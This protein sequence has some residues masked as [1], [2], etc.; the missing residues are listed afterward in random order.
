MLAKSKSWLS[1]LRRRDEEDAGDDGRQFGMFAGVFTPTVLTILGAIMYLRT[2]WVVGNAGL[3]GAIAI[4]LL[5][6]VITFTTGLAVSSVATNTRVGA[7]GAFAIISQSLGLEVGGSIGIPLVLAQSISIALYVLAFS[8]AW[9]R[10]FPAH[11]EPLVAVLSF[12]AVFIIAYISAKFASRTQFLILIIVGFSLVSIFLASFPILGQP[13]FTQDPVLVGDFQDAN[14]WETFAVFFPAVTGIMVG[15]SMSGTLRKPRRDIPIGTMSA[16]FL[17]LIIYLLLAFWLARIA[18]PQELLNNSTIMVDK[19]VWGWAVLAGILGATFSSALGSLV[20]APRVMQALALYE[21]F[22]FSDYFAQEAKNGEP[23]HAMYIAGGVGFVALLAALAGGGLDAIAGIITMFFLITYGMLNVVVLIEQTL[24]TV[25]FRPMLRVSRLVPFIGM[26]G[27]TFVMFLIQPIFSLIAAVLVVILYFYLSRRKLAILDTDVRSGLSATVAEWGVRRTRDMQAAPERTWK[28]VV[29][30]PVK[31]SGTL[32]G[33]YL[34]LRA[35][36]SPK[37]TVQ[38]L[39]IHPA[40]T[41]ARLAGLRNLARAFREDGIYAEAT[42]LEEEDF[43]NGVRVTTQILRNTFFRPNILFLHLRQDSDLQEL[44]E[45][46]DKTAAYQMGIALL[47]RH[48]VVEMGREQL[49]NVW[50]SNQGPDW[51]I[52]LRHSNMDLALLLAYQLARNW[53]GQITLYMAVPDQDTQEK[54]YAFLSE[55]IVLARLPRETSQKV[56][57]APFADALLEV[58]RPDLSIFGLPREPDL[59]FAQD[60]V[61]RVNGSCLFVRDSG[62]ESALA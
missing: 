35:I 25:S 20:A 10:I 12:A 3:I 45:L 38:A 30:V 7:G 42:L 9:L 2:G 8:E 60:L 55:L 27:C 58:R 46:V 53:N 32:S 29:L 56:I 18:T 19:A 6:H 37:G 49:I 15:I 4:I 54:A 28:P 13:G 34:F 50:V 31:E 16:I 59:S 33:S 5:A 52:D 22:P 47:A 1:R 44:Q 11:N 62:D 39:G 61:Q 51:K 41:V 14:F 43:V 21:I 48:P 26:L 36:A 17:T 40:G 24:D 23:R 57:V